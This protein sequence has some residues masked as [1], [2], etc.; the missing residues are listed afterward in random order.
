MGLHNNPRTSLARKS[1]GTR[2]VKAVVHFDLLAFW[3]DRSGLLRLGRE[4]AVFALVQRH[5]KSEKKY[6]RRKVRREPS[7]S[8]QDE[9]VSCDRSRN[10]ITESVPCQN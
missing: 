7:P 4:T 9:H 10:H 8:R 1:F 2:V 6:Y 3:C 5:D